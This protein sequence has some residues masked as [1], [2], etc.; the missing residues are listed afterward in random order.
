MTLGDFTKVVN[1]QNVTFEVGTSGEIITLY[2]NR[3]TDESTIDRRNSRD[4]PIDTPTFSLIEIT[5]DAV[6]AED[7]YLHMRALRQLTS[8]GALPTEQV[9]VIATNIGVIADDWTETGTYILRRM[10]SIAQEAGRYEVN[11]TMRIQGL[12]AVT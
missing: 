8:R 6:L 5:G 1:A 2:H 4:G 3:I 9:K 11:L 10:E 7:L 12:L